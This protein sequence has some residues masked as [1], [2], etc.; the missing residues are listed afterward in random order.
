[1]QVFVL[2]LEKLLAPLS[3]L[4][5]V[6]LHAGYWNIIALIDSVLRSALFVPSTIT[7]FSLAFSASYSRTPNP[8]PPQRPESL[9][10]AANRPKLASYHKQLFDTLYALVRSGATDASGHFAVHEAA[11]S[12]IPHLLRWFLGAARGRLE[13]HSAID[14]KST[15]LNSS[16]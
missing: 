1:M 6:S 5:Y 16:H 3:M 10:T 9:H 15:R 8:G 13:R 4:R 12:L 7:D 11:L 2:V 14:R